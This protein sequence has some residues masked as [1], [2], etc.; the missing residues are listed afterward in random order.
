MS[1]NFLFP[2]GVHEKTK[3]SRNLLS[4]KS[5]INISLYKGRNSNIWSNCRRAPF[6]AAVA[7]II[8]KPYKFRSWYPDYRQAALPRPSWGHWWFLHMRIREEGSRAYPRRPEPP[9]LKPCASSNLS[10]QTHSPAL[11][12]HWLQSDHQKAIESWPLSSS[13]AILTLELGQ[14]LRTL[15]SSSGFLLFLLQAASVGLT[16]V[17]GVIKL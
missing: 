12:M 2:C 11:G 13:P 14:Q 6:S 5:S 1:S 7:S 9:G 3:T 8:S 16:L 15:L 4:P 17:Q 10:S